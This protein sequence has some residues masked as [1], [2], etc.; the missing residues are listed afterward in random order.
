M[1][2]APELPP[3]RSARWETVAIGLAILMVA[4][5]SLKAL[6]AFGRPAPSE[7]QVVARL[8]REN[9]PQSRH[10]SPER[11]AALCVRH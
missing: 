2:R 8:P 11:A 5:V 7:P 1:D 10:L 3:V 6:G 9:F 4:V